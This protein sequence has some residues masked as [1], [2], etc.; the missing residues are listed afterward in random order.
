MSNTARE[1][2]CDSLNIIWTIASKDI[3][4]A[5]K[6]MFVIL[7]IIM[8]SIMLL[9]PKVIPFIFEQPATVVPIF[10]AGSSRLAT[11]L[12][13]NA[14]ISIQKVRSEQELKSALCNAI[15]PEIGLLIRADFDQILAESERIELQGYV[16]WNKR[17]QT[18]E[19]RP[20]L[21]EQLSKALGRSV[22][23]HVE[24][25][26]VY[27]PSDAGLLP[28]I[29]TVNSVVILLVMG[30]IHIP[31]LLFEEKQTKTMQAL[32][33]SP[34][35]ISQ[36]VISKALAGLF[37]ILVTAAVIFAISWVDVIHWS[38]VLQFVIAG[39]IFSVAVGLVLGSFFD[40]QQDVAGWV[41]VLMVVFIGAIFV[42]MIG[43]E[44]PAILE[45]ILP[46]LPP[47]ALAEICRA[48]FAEDVSMS[49]AA[50]NLGIVLAA[51]LPLYALVIWKVRRSDR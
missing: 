49:Q 37:Y 19:V 27:P 51:S 18:T 42:K 30:I 33:V 7:I 26:I 16:C 13:E 47:V 24:G 36:V 17:F 9:L 45:S 35:S 21:E 28:S 20:K 3:I 44:L 15:Y 43:L 40:K 38:I 2:I 14:N 22:S 48:A 50:L 6:S 32:L 23:I 46:W 11:E 41:T 5:L 39:G 10:D 34:A 8:S 12:Q 31:N 29:P 4:D 1:R 25:N